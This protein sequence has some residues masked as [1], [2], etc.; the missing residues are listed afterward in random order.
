MKLS[1]SLLVSLFSFVF[2]CR[3]CKSPPLECCLLWI[4]VQMRWQPCDFVYPTWRS[5]LICFGMPTLPRP[6]N[7]ARPSPLPSKVLKPLAYAGP[8]ESILGEADRR[9]TPLLPPL[10]LRQLDR[11]LHH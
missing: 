1:F 10:C 3:A 2:L 8:S 7:T 6:Y 9:F 4:P 11:C 5:C